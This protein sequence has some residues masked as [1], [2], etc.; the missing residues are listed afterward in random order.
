MNR[1]VI[2]TILF[3]SIATMMVFSI[4]PAMAMS[5]TGEVTWI[6]PS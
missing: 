4:L 2:F 6:N 3:T 5:A 1:I